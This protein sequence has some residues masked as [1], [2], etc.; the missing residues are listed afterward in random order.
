[1]PE[2]NVSELCPESRRDKL[3]LA[4]R[5]LLLKD[6]IYREATLSRDG[7]VE[8]L[9][10]NRFDLEDAFL[11]CFGMPYSEQINLLRLNDA[12]VML[13]ESDLS[14]AEISEKASFG[15]VRTFQMQFRKKYNMSPRDYRK[16]AK[17]KKAG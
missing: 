10:I 15:T 1:M 12:I 14:M 13:E 5:D 8:R 11:F 2:S 9:G 6:K 7:L 16:L 17:E 3:C 4:L